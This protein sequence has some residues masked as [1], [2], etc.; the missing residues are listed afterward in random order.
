[1]TIVD[2]KS[3]NVTQSQAPSVPLSFPIY[4][5]NLQHR[6]QDSVNWDGAIKISIN[7]VQ[8][9]F[10]FDAIIT[11]K[12]FS[13]KEFCI[14][15]PPF[16]EQ[17]RTNKEKNG[18]NCRIESIHLYLIPKWSKNTVKSWQITKKNYKYSHWIRDLRWWPE[19][20]ALETGQTIQIEMN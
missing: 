18:H 2:D 7:I 12:S 6:Y 13:A 19:S 17:R 3:L 11:I 15:L 4:H 5:F 10:H 1:M 16:L 20:G 8:F 9:H 14:Y